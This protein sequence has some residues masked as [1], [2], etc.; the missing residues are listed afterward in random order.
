M[1]ER[2]KK[3]FGYVIV[4]I[5]FSGIGA[6]AANVISSSDIAY[7]PQ[8]NEF[9]V[10]NVKEALDKM[11]NTLYPA[12]L[13]LTAIKFAVSYVVCPPIADENIILFY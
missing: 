7:Q 1:K 5:V 4:A 12:C 8:N 2:V 3:I 10:T 13:N 11:Y 6:Y 9:N